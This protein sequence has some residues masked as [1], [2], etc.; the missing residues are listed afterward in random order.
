VN[1]N[2]VIRMI[3]QYGEYVV[4]T[5]NLD[6]PGDWHDPNSKLLVLDEKLRIEELPFWYNPKSLIEVTLERLI[7]EKEKARELLQ[8][9]FCMKIACSVARRYYEGVDLEF[10]YGWLD[11][12]S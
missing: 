7:R 3:F 10:L 4:M 9:G 12:S 8:M 2:I 1:N 5:V 6:I 11:G